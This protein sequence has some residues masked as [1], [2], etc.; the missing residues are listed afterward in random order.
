[1]REPKQKQKKYTFMSYI[2]IAIPLLAGLFMAFNPQGLIKPDDPSFEKK[3][4]RFRKIGYGLIVVAIL[5]TLVKI[6]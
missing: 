5:Y 1:M 6:L 4:E 3:R 2:D